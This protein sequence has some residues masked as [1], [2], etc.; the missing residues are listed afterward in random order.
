MGSD[1]LDYQKEFSVGLLSATAV[2]VVFCAI[3]LCFAVAAF[4]LQFF[5]INNSV[6]QIES[7][8]TAAAQSLATR[9]LPEDVLRGVTQKRDV[10]SSYSDE[11]VERMNARDNRESVME[12]LQGH[13]E[14]DQKKKAMDIYAEFGVEDRLPSYLKE[15]MGIGEVQPGA[16]QPRKPPVDP[17]D[18]QYMTLANVKDDVFD[19]DDD[20]AV[21][22]KK[23]AVDPHDPNYVTLAG[24]QNDIF[25]DGHHGAA[26]GGGN[27]EMGRKKAF[28]DARDPN[29]MTL[30]GIQ[31]DVFDKDPKG[32]AGQKKVVDAHDPNY[33]TLAGIQ[34]DVFN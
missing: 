15:G 11:T 4:L 5:W 9:K 14:P 16:G 20:A 26:R 24:I 21:G 29:Y 33:M 8:L 7:M 32:G 1:A 34:N 27:Q 19:D 23:A 18:Q 17:H 13:T 28:V 30:A 22:K 31:D 6:S 10:D 2:S 25:D 3:G 12:I